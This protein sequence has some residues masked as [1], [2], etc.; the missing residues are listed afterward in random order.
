V[1]ANHFAIC[2]QAAQAKVN[3]FPADTIFELG[4]KVQSNDDGT[5][6]VLTTKEV[7]PASTDAVLQA[8][9]WAK[10]LRTMKHIVDESDLAETPSEAKDV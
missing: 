8:A 1:V 5:W 6:Y 9:Q 7:G 4:G 2:R 3:R 10:N